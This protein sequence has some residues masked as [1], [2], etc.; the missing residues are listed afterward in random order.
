MQDNKQENQVLDDDILR[1]K[2]DLR[3]AFDAM[4]GSISEEAA[5][6]E[7]V[8]EPKDTPVIEAEFI[9]LPED[10]LDDEQPAEA[11]VAAEPS[12]ESINVPPIQILSFDAIQRDTL[13][14]AE[15]SPDKPVSDSP[16][17]EK[18]KIAPEETPIEPHAEQVKVVKMKVKQIVQQAQEKIVSIT[19]QKDQLQQQVNKTISENT[20]LQDELRSGR[21]QLEQ[22]LQAFE[23]EKIAFREEIQTLLSQREYA[24]RQLEDMKSQLEQKS[25]DPD[26][27]LEDIRELEKELHDKSETV[28][29]QQ[30]QLDSANE[31]LMGFSQLQEANLKL[32]KELDQLGDQQPEFASERL[33]LQQENQ[34]LLKD[35]DQLRAQTKDFQ[36]IAEQAERLRTELEKTDI[37]LSQERAHIR[38][39]TGTVKGLEEELAVAREQRQDLAERLSTKEQELEQALSEHKRLHDEYNGFRNQENREISDMTFQ[40]EDYRD[41]IRDIESQLEQVRHEYEAFQTQANGEINRLTER[42]QQLDDQSRT[43]SAEA[44]AL[45]EQLQHSSEQ[46]DQIQAV[47]IDLNNA[48]DALSKERLSRQELQQQYE[49][50][51]SMVSELRRQKDELL[52]HNQQQQTTESQLRQEIGQLQESVRSS[53]AMANELV[54]AKHEIEQLRQQNRKLEV[55][56]DKISSIEGQ[57]EQVRHEYEAFQTQANGEINLLTER[58]QQLDDQSRTLTAEAAALREQLQHSSE[59]ADRIQAVEIDLNNANDALSKER[60]SRQELQQQYEQLQSTVSE[61]NREKDELF[62]HRQQQQT[63]ENQLRQEIGQLQESVRSFEAM[64]NELIETKDEIEQL[65]QQ[66]R[67]LEDQITEITVSEENDFENENPAEND[68]AF[69][70][71]GSNGTENSDIPVFDLADQIME[72]QR[73]S[74]ANRRQ[75]PEPALSVPSKNSIRNVVHQYVGSANTAVADVN[76]RAG[77]EHYP[78]IDS[79]L[80]PF[81]QD[82]L[83]E[84]V[85]KDI[86]SYNRKNHSPLS[87]PSMKN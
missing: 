53:E 1:C 29:I 9:A 10:I 75:R 7:S 12:Q 86:T 72:E 41:K 33:Q 59:Q 6:E 42:N 78:W 47:E 4:V 68:S 43:L 85:R 66:N 63:T 76:K 70:F 13:E 2:A 16:I 52:D 39:I 46:A 19:A 55:N 11:V 8:P 83:R 84:I 21:Q 22:Q 69:D 5:T 35:I 73:R 65:K 54:E 80:T 18:D 31:K 25:S 62:G 27:L 15:P 45:R 48:N 32:K 38:Q 50:L 23:T 79:S 20:H 3:K 17:W 60:L 61:L 36:V 81:Q 51:Q 77:I 74:A 71:A 24:A 34:H 14:I 28:R 57:F 44:A 64:A 30:Q 58:N 87:H 40:L 26:A 67:N 56:R 37:I 49:Q 82:V